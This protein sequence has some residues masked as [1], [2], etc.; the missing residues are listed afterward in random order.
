M[1]AGEKGIVILAPAPYKIRKTREMIDDDT[2]LPVLGSDGKV[3]QEEIEIVQP[4]FKPVFVFDVSQTTGPDL[5]TLGVEELKGEVER[6]EELIAALTEAAPVPVTFE[7]FEGEAKGYFS[8]A[9]NKIVVREGM[10]EAQTLKTLVHETAHSLLHGKEVLVSDLGNEKKNRQT[11]EVE[12]ESVAYVVSEHFGLDTSEYSFGYIAGWSSERSMKELKGAL[13]TI[14]KTADSIIT[15]VEEKMKQREKKQEV[16][17]KEGKEHGKE[18]DQSGTRT[19]LA[20]IAGKA[21]E[22]KGRAEQ[23]EKNRGGNPKKRA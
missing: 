17:R 15:Q 12:A 6:Y 18:N 19:A 13:T 11:K 8:P 7:N 1:K 9:E 23:E 2:G 14:K 20:E 5:P 3:K 22:I 21:T 10:S 16:E 4:G